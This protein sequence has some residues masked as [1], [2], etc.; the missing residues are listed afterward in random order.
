MVDVLERIDGVELRSQ[1]LKFRV[2]SWGEN[3]L[4]VRATVLYEINDALVWALLE[5]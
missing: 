1:R 4:R 5:P 3:S 2:Q